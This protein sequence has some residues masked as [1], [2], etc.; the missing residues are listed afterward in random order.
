MFKKIAEFDNRVSVYWT[1]RHFSEKT[2]KWL[3]FY[4]RLGDGYIWALFALFLFWIV[5]WDN[6]LPILW[7]A[8]MA[9]AMS[10]IIYEVVKLS[11]KRPRPFAANPVIKAEVPP[12]DKYSFPSGHTMNNL[13]VASAV[14]FAVPQYGWIMM[15]LPLTW[16]LL[17]VYFGVHW[18]TDIICGFLLGVVSFVLGHLLWIAIF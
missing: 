12:L 8:L 13:A 7:Q 9:L 14:F 1:N 16:G 6:F 15:L 3:R 10:L 4:V 18:L 2:N 11:T 17:R 5:G